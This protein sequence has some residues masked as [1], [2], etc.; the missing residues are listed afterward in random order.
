M[1]SKLRATTSGT[2]AL[3]LALFLPACGS[4]EEEPAAEPVGESLA[5]S[6]AQL[7]ECHDWLEASEEEKLATIEDV[8]SHVNLEGGTGLSAPELSDEEALEVFD[9]GCSRPTAYNYRLYKMYTRAV[10]FQPLKDIAEG[11]TPLP[12]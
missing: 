6:V 11:K 5:G 12:E 3:L 4:G 7:A 10:A 1:S 2:A 9:T 8:R